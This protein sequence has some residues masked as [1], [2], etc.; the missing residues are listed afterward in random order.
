MPTVSCS[1]AQRQAGNNA[2]GQ[3][4]PT[5]SAERVLTLSVP[6]GQ[7]RSLTGSDIKR[8]SWPEY[9]FLYEVRDM[10]PADSLCVMHVPA[11]DIELL[12]QWI[13]VVQRPHAAVPL[14]LICNMTLA[15]LFLMGTWFSP[16]TSA[17]IRWDE[18]AHRRR[19]WRRWRPC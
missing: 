10:Q 4:S 9:T 12:L 8:M 18:A 5:S 6:S 2:T 13:Y 14:G 16:S 3:E 15:L 7:E 19:I 1:L 17:S 11:R